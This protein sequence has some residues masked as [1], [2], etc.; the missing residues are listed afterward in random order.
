M[1]TPGELL[2]DDS[3]KCLLEVKKGKARKFV[4]IKDGV[5]I[6][7]LVVFK[8][9]NFEK[10]VRVAR[11][12]SVRGAAY[13]GTVRGDGVDIRFELAR[14]HGFVT[15][16]G[17]E[18]RLKEF[19]REAASLK[20]EPT[21]VIVDNLSSTDESDA[22]DGSPAEEEVSPAA[23]T[24][25][26]VQESEEEKFIRLLK[27]ILPH[28]KRALQADSPMRDELQRTVREAQEFGKK[29]EFGPGIGALRSVGELTKKVLSASE[30]VKRDEKPAS[31][32]D[33]LKAA[34][35]LR[36]EEWEVRLADMDDRF[37]AALAAQSSNSNKL[38]KVMAYAQNEA[39]KQRFVKALV[40]LDRLERLMEES[41]ATVSG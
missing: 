26:A 27:S 15:P 19:L 37:A 35:R 29:R 24:D 36:R 32:A 20:F 18:I 38:Q 21:Y 39:R 23:A 41:A 28:V 30:P 16:P 31:L 1:Q 2:S 12:D 3:K 5:Q 8:A 10:V 13:W 34:Q 14:K 17:S 9:G 6:D 11:E 4:M 7:R 25:D 40:G 33:K 22:Q